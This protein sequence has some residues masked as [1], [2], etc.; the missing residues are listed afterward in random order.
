[1]RVAV[2]GLGVTGFSVADT[3]V[4]LEADVLVVAAT[5]PPERADLL[6]VIGAALVEQPDLSTVPAALEQFDPELIVVS[7]GFHPDHPLLAWAGERGIP[8]WGDIEL[9]WRVRD[10]VRAAEWITVTGTNG[11]TT[12]VQLTAHLLGSAGHRV[13]AVGNI[14]TPVLDA[15]RDPIGFDALVVELSSYQ[16]HWIN[17][18]LEGAISAL[19]SVCLNLADDHLD[20]HGSAAAYAA[21]KGKVYDNTR[22]ACVYNKADEATLRMVENADVF[23]GCRAIGFDLGTPGPSDLG[24]VDDIVVDRAFHD[25]R[26]NEAIELTTHGEL[27]A[28]GL[29]APHSVANVLAASALA[30]AF[31]VEA[32][33][34]RTALATFRIDHHRTE[35]VAEH[36]GILWVNDSKATNPHAA[37][38]SLA[39]HASVVWVVGGLLKGVDVGELVRDHAPRLRAAVVI[40]T[41]RSALLAAFERHAPGLPVFEVDSTDTDEV[42]PTAVRL[43]AAA[44]AVGDTILLA[45]AAASMD[46]FSDYAD[47]GRR[48]ATAVTDLVGG[49]GHDDNPRPQDTPAE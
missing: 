44:A 7:P 22:I 29:S 18:A 17:S 46:Q 21:A 16:L 2:L 41:D 14:G 39:A 26:R 19:A 36:G 23:E 9:A 47:R 1:L 5:A 45:P 30:R 37:R 48:F 35:V 38:A 49:A 6:A 4:E 12:T 33:I 11:K 15:V 40:G 3:L 28:A 32:A 13:A 27:L 10:K 25:D 43:A 31:G 34:I 42:M 24:L 20:W 8:I